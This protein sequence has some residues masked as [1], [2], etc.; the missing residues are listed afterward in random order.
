[1]KTTTNGPQTIGQIS[2]YFKHGDLFLSPEEYQRENAWDLKQKKLL[3]DSIFTG[4]DIP[5]FYLW[6]IDQ[7]TLSN[8]Y[9]DGDMKKYY[10]KLLEKK[11]L[12]N[13]EDD[14]YI[15]EAVD[16]QQR[17]RTILEYMGFTPPNKKCF[18]GSWLD[19][20]PAMPETPM[21]KGKKYEQLNVNQKLKFEQYSLSVVVLEDSTIDEIRDMFLRLQNG[22]P[23]NAQQKRDAMGSNIGNSVR[24]LA[25]LSFFTKSVPFPN[26][27]SNHNLV[28]AQM[29][30]LELKNEIA[31][32]TSQQLD[33]IYEHYKKT[34]IDPAVMGRTKKIIGILGD[35]FPSNNPHL[36]QNYA[37]SL[38]WLLS[39]I[40]FTY[41]IPS[42]EYPKIR[43]N[44]EKL[45]AARMEAMTRGYN[46]GKDEIYEDLSLAMSRGN[47]GTEALMKRHEIIGLYLFDNVVLK[48]IPKL[49]PKRNFTFEEKLLLYHRSGGK[50]QLEH[51]GKVCGRSIDFD[52]AVVDHIKP[53]S[54][55]GKTELSNGRIAYNLCNI[56]R[57]NRN[58]FDPKK[59]CHLDDD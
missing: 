54:L 22:T 23:L 42:S 10:K 8:G 56:A 50:C 13:D 7:R 19:P 36:N 24:E 49:D 15:Y 11:R 30:R 14:P 16:G 53:H 32:C 45:D 43:S 25:G 52:D 6:K 1:M 12:E 28:A 46:K 51:N 18:R 55:G 3:I 9:P 26:S 33:K 47:L 41:D 48:E 39:R 35:I 4:F 20:F 21:A 34:A 40:L 2:M 57:G 27:A 59:D 44:F 38:Y 58:N 31:S 37:L 5:K 29:L 17:I